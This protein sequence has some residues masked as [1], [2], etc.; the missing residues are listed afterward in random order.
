VDRFKKVPSDSALGIPDLG[1]YACVG[2]I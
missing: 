1:K 2:E